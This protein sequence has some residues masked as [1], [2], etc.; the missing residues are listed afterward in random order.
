[1]T[2]NNTAPATIAASYKR[3]EKICGF[4]IGVI[5]IVF[6]L[7][8]MHGDTTLLDP[9]MRRF[10]AIP[11]YLALLVLLYEVVSSP[12]DFRVYVPLLIVWVIQWIIDNFHLAPG[13]DMSIQWSTL[14]LI[15]LFC[16]MRERVW[17]YGFRVYRLFLVFGS[18]FGIIAFVGFLTG[19]FP[20]LETVDYYNNSGGPGAVYQ[21]Y[22]FSYIMV[23]IEGIRLC[24]LFN[25]PGYL[26]TISALVLIADGFNMRSLGNWLILIAAVFSF[27]IAFFLLIGI[28]WGARMLQSAKALLIVL[29]VVAVLLFVV[30]PHIPEDSLV[31]QLVVSRLTY[32]KDE[33]QLAGDSRTTDAFLVYWDKTIRDGRIFFGQ[34]GGYFNN[35][36]VGSLSYKKEIVQHGL[37]GC[38]L[39][40]GLLV[41]ACLKYKQRSLK[42]WLLIICFFASIY[43]RPSIFLYNYMIIL[44]GGMENVRIIDSEKKKQLSTSTKKD[45]NSNLCVRPV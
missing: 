36:D 18:V 16:M 23:G 35:K 37:F 7:A 10:V 26:G 42:W 28:Y 27:S 44:F 45:E 5:A 3:R 2:F 22:P 25:E 38:F 40:W 4:A 34:G 6:S 14:I 20:P 24:G 1:M 30:V 19:L 32:D 9:S 12:K 33:N 41:F 43:Q 15:M 8:I 17:H 29:S 21:V 39:M 13:V 11:N 31:G